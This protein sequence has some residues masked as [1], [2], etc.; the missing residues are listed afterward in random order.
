MDNYKIHRKVKIRNGY[1]ITATLTDGDNVRTKHFF[2]SGNEEPTDGEL[3][4]KLDHMLTR[5]IEKN[6][7]VLDEQM[8]V[9]EVEELLRNKGYLTDDQ[10]LE[11]LI[12]TLIVSWTD[13]HP[14]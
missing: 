8:L 6:K 3:S 12:D 7:E 11:D 9:T 5:F 14:W 10:V 1:E 4:A 13:I 2:Y